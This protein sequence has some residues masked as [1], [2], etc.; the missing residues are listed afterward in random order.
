MRKLLISI[1]AVAAVASA[2][3]AMAA[4][5][6]AGG[7]NGGGNS[8]GAGMHAMEANHSAAATNS[9]GFKSADRDMGLDRAND[10]RN[11]HSFMRRHARK[12]KFKNK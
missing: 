10:R 12:S 6:G 8:G 9:N 4:G 3:V 5:H 11:K 2:S 7:G 1:A